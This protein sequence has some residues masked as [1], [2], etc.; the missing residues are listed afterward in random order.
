MAFETIKATRK[1][2]EGVKVLKDYNKDIY[3]PLEDGTSEM[4]KNSSDIIDKAIK[5][6]VEAGF[7]YMVVKRETVY[8]ENKATM[9]IQYKGFYDKSAK[10]FAEQGY[11]VFDLSKAREYLKKRENY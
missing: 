8:E 10:L 3:N 4:V 2:G 1:F 5:E 7:N 11:E 6:N 9:K